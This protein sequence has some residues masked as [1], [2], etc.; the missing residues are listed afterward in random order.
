MATELYEARREDC[1]ARLEAVR[2]DLREQLATFET[3]SETPE[4]AIYATGSLG[5]LEA[6]AYSDLDAFFFLSGTS[7]ETPLGRIRDVKILNAVVLTAERNGFPDF[8]NDGEYLK[9]LHVDDV[10][11]H[12]GGRGDD[13]NNAFTG[14]MLMILESKYL[15]NEIVFERF[16]SE[17]IETYFK[18]FH[19]HLKSF[20]PIFLLN[21]I[22]RF[23]RTICLNYENGRHWRAMSPERS[24]R[25]HLDNLKLRF[26]RLNIC[27]SFIAHLLA[28]G[29]TLTPSDVL[30]TARMTPVERL[31]DLQINNGELGAVI[32]VLLD[33]YAWFLEAVGREK[34]EVLAWIG[35]EE[36]RIEAF[37]HAAQFVEAMG[38]L[39][40]DIADKNGYLRYLII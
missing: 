40:R 12:I 22:L 14:R 11:G 10:I 25:G 28:K 31:C 5:R 33:Q 29:A 15:Y 7:S 19:D 32:D 8:S 39:V 3:G 37:G 34:S 26:S 30:D 36:S 20:R 24:A 18:D 6:T 35:D 38:D 21:D 2:Q 17:I 9:F 4:V 23:W 27:Y 13:Y 16:R 1:L